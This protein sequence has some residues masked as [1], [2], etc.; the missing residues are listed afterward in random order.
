MTRS[1]LLLFVLC[2][3]TISVSAHED[4]LYLSSQTV[5]SE[6]LPV[7]HF[8][9]NA[10]L[11]TISVILANQIDIHNPVFDFVKLRP[12]Y[13]QSFKYTAGMSLKTTRLDNSMANYNDTS[14]HHFTVNSHSPIF[15]FTHEMMID[16]T[17]GL[18]YS[19]GYSSSN[20]YF[21][22]QYYGSK[23]Y[24]ISLNPQLFVHRSYNFEYYV[25]LKIGL[26]YE[27]NRLDENP[28]EILRRIYPT[29]FHMFTG[30]TIAGINYL[31]SDHLA[32]TAELSIWSAETI[33]FGISY[34]FL[35]KQKEKMPELYKIAY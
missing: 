32:M 18:S 33:N 11:D 25:K 29:K 19:L 28:S 31:I 13:N 10:D 12:F 22:N 35:T 14:E 20:I 16:S 7:E 24:F 15:S 34:R 4:S 17:F 23:Q 2:F 3:A 26:L 30:V 1:I 5:N 21:D 8:P 6:D 27:D 9:G